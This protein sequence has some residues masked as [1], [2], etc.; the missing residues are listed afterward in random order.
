MEIKQI[1]CMIQR[2]LCVSLLGKTK[3]EYYRNLDEKNICDSK[4]FWKV[5]NEK[6]TLIENDKIINP[7][8][9]TAKVLKAFFPNIVQNLHFQQYTVDDPICENILTAVV[10]IK[11]VLLQLRNV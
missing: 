11:K 9:G 3:R 1:T 10:T 4:T 5:V 8:K 7:K 2:N 6:I